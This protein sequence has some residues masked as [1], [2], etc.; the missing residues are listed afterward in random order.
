MM[1]MT[2]VVVVVVVAAAAGLMNE[3]ATRKRA[4]VDVSGLTT[5]GGANEA[6]PTNGHAK[7]DHNFDYH[8]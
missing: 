2:V 7:A 8:G 6:S 4:D 3:R 5:H 1:K